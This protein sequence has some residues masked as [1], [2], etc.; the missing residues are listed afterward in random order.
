MPDWRKNRS[1][2]YFNFQPFRPFNNGKNEGMQVPCLLTFTGR[3]EYLDI[4]KKILWILPFLYLSNLFCNKKIIWRKNRPETMKFASRGLKR[5][6]TM[7]DWRKKRTKNDEKKRIKIHGKDR[8]TAGTLKK[9]RICRTD[10]KTG[11][12]KTGFYCSCFK[13]SLVPFEKDIRFHID[14]SRRDRLIFFWNI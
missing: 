4:L 9:R 13:S 3:S 2:V 8:K 10:E 11:D 5:A 14:A 12:E 6:T 1:P 7:P